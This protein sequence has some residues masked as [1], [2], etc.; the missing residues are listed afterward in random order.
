MLPQVLDGK[1]ATYFNRAVVSSQSFPRSKPLEA[2][3]DWLANGLQDAVP[4]VLSESDAFDCAIYHLSDGRWILPSFKKFSGRGSLTYFDKGKDTKSQ[5]GAD[6]LRVKPNI[7]K[8]KRDAIAKLMHDK[9]IVSYKGGREAAVLTGST[10]FT[11]EAQTVQANLLHILHSPQIADLY[12][13]RAHLLAANKKTSDIAK[14][15]GWHKVKAR[16]CGSSSPL[17]R[18]NNGSSCRPSSRRFKPRNPR[19][20]SARSRPRMRI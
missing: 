14:L 16:R 4:E 9:F 7:S 1:I 20:C 10:N 6:Y 17:S 8:H 13:Q 15:A 11:P 2:Q 18:A 3:M 19:S 12:A 5:A